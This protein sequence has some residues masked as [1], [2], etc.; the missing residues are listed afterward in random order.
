MDGKGLKKKEAAFGSKMSKKLT[1]LLFRIE[2]VVNC[3]WERP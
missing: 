1:D 3:E 2:R